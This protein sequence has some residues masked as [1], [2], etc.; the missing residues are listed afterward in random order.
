MTERRA[1]C[2]QMLAQEGAPH[3]I[4]RLLCKLEAE[5]ARVLE[6]RLGLRGEPVH[7]LAQVRA[8]TTRS[9]PRARG[10]AMPAIGVHAALRPLQ[11]CRPCASIF[12]GGR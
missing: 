3:D 10:L 5:E 4:E 9:R 1:G 6:L 12:R 2:V 7:N 11:Q 8:R